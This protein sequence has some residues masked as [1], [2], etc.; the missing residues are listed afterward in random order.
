[1]LAHPDYG[2]KKISTPKQQPDL[3]RSLD[4]DNVVDLPGT[5]TERVAIINIFREYNVS[6]QEWSAS[7]ATE[8]NIKSIDNPDIL[9][10]ATHGF[11]LNDIGP[12]KSESSFL[13]L[14]DETLKLNPLLRSGL[15]MAGCQQQ[16]WKAADDDRQQEDG[17][18]TAFEAATL[19]LDQTELVVLSACETGLGEIKNG[20]GVYGL[21]RAFAM[22]GARQIIMS[23]WKVDDQATQK[24][25]IAFYKEWLKANDT[26]SAFKLAQA[27]LKNTY[28]APYYWGAFILTGN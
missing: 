14:R 18:L 28:P 3:N 5:E 6:L 25:M 10:I 23:L 20:E 9:H 24:F 4:L 26:A 27:N 1:M 7:E 22:A 8:E 15:L 16:T 2:N 13:G 21:Q 12:S 19:R 11:F 17:I